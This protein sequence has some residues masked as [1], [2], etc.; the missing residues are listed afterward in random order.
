MN[1][2]YRFNKIYVYHAYELPEGAKGVTIFPNKF[3]GP[4]FSIKNIFARYSKST[5]H[6]WCN[7]HTEEWPFFNFLT[8]LNLIDDSSIGYQQ[9]NSLL[10][11]QISLII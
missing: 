9:K 1:L 6:I 3:L 10:N 5:L 8:N 2:H 11:S 4:D 7:L